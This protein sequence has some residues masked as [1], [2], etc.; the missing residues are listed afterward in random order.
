MN[1]AIL[2]PSYLP[3]RGYFDQIRRV[4]VFVFYDD[5]QYDHHGWRNRNRIKTANGVRWLT[6]PVRQAGHRTELRS[7]AETEIHWDAKPWT[8]SHFD[9]LRSAYRDAPFWSRY[10]PLLEAVYSRHDRYLAD[11]TIETT[12]LIARELG[13]PTRLLRS[14][15]LPSRGTKTER[16]LSILSHLGAT[17]YLTGPAARNYLDEEMLQNAGVDVEYMTYDYPPYEQLHPPYEPHV[18]IVDLLLMTGP[19]ARHHFGQ[20]AAAPG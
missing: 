6:V 11:L 19:D 5:V 9:S 8:R 4:D 10:E 16:L 3:W 1:C 20:V 7:I 2:Q 14:S 13:F 18:S 15:S 12:T 17:H